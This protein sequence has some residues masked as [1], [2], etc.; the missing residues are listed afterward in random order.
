MGFFRRLIEEGTKQINEA[1]K[2]IKEAIEKAE[3]E[4]AQNQRFHQS[5]SSSQPQNNIHNTHFNPPPNYTDNSYPYNY[6]NQISREQYLSNLRVEQAHNQIRRAAEN[7]EMIGT[8]GTDNVNVIRVQ[9]AR[10]SY[11]KYS[12]T[13]PPG[14]SQKQHLSNLRVQLAHDQI[15]RYEES[16][17]MMNTIGTNTRIEWIDGP[18]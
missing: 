9:R 14:I 6:P 8:I 4:Q 2:I 1:N 17:M 18:I 11:N 5:Q 16:S 13:P 12:S 7:L 15:R 10:P 3:A